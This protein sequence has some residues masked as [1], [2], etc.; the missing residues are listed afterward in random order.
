MLLLP[1]IKQLL[2]KPPGLWYQVTC[3]HE[4]HCAYRIMNEGEG[5]CKHV[6]EL[7]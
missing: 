6:S 7:Y 4:A 1:L 3:H 5:V 2:V